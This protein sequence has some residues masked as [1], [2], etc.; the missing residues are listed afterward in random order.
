MVV[1]IIYFTHHDTINVST[2]DLQELK[3]LK[4]DH[5]QLL[6]LHHFHQGPKGLLGIFY[7][8]EKNS[9]NHIDSL[10]IAYIHII[11]TIS[12]Q[13]VFEHPLE[14]YIFRKSWTF[15]MSSED[16]FVNLDDIFL[17]GFFFEQFF[18]SNRILSMKSL[19]PL[20]FP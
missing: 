4:I 9:R 2:M 11:Y 5:P 6:I 18:E 3:I 14:I 17:F 13:Y 8:I 12:Y 16:I 20:F 7:M 10:H 1:K 19:C 15:W